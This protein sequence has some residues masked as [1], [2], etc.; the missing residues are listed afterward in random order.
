MKRLA[1]VCLL[2]LAGCSSAPIA[3]V[4]DC[5]AP[6]HLEPA[7]SYHGGVGLPQQPTV[8]PLE[9]P[10][11][12]VPPGGDNLPPPVPPTEGVLPR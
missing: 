9:G 7:A 12:I 5:V 2:L 4:L 1:A 3:D 6:G 8:P 10:Q 11:P